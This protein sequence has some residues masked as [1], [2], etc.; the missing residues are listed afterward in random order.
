MVL[1]NVVVIAIFGDDRRRWIHGH[2][3]SAL[4]GIATTVAVS[5]SVRGKCDWCAECGK[6]A[7]DKKAS[8]PTAAFRLRTALRVCEVPACGTRGRRTVAIVADPVRVMLE[9]G[10]KKRVVACAFDWPGWDRSARIGEDVLAIL[11]AYRSRYAKVAALAGYG[12]E[13]GA[14]GE[15][16]VVERLEG[17]GMTDFYGLSGRTAAPE[18]DPMT[19][20][21]YERKIALLRA[22]WSTFDDVAAHVPPE[23]RKG[24]RGGGRDRD[25]I[26]RHVNG[27][28]IYEFAPKVGVKVPLE[29]RDDADALRAYRETFVDAIREHHARGESAGS[30]VL[31]FLI[32]RCAWH[33]LDHAWELED[34]AEP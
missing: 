15:L 7:L 10:K 13:F 27:A 5:M 21:E 29:T 16:E 28:E 32:R 25:Q 24:P 6:R 3:D 23:L 31:Q 22:S 19:E 14:T 17:I 1:V 4:V 34:R 11:A 20:L 8:R 18:Y 9:R 2:D 26:I 30:W 33:M 12:V